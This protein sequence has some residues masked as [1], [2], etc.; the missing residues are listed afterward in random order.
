MQRFI[1]GVVMTRFL[2]VFVLVFVL[3]GCQA[4]VIVC[5][6]VSHDRMEI[7]ERDLEVFLRMSNRVEV[8]SDLDGDDAVGDGVIL[9]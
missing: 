4:R 2:W 5:D 6:P 1:D 3:V 9:K 8:R 7:R